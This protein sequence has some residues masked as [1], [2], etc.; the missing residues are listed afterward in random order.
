MFDLSA[1]FMFISTVSVFFAEQNSI[2]IGINCVLKIV[3][4]NHLQ[5]FIITHNIPYHFPTQFS[6]DFSLMWKPKISL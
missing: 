1:L 5:A 6:L 4:I 3:I 2:M